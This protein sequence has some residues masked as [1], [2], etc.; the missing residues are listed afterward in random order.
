VDFATLGVQVP[1]QVLRDSVCRNAL[2]A[3]LARG[4]IVS[5]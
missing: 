1:S 4:A 2:T 5:A 3:F